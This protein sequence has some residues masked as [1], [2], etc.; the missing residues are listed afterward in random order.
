MK[1]KRK[2]KSANGC[3]QRISTLVALV[4]PEQSHQLRLEQ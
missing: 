1:Q 2:Q 4:P 3:R